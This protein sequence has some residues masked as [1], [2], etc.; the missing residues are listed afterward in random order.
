MKHDSLRVEFDGAE[1]E[2][3]YQDLISLE[4]EL[5]DRLA[6]MFRLTVALPPRPDGT[7]PHLD[8]DRLALWRKVV[9]TAGLED[10]ARRLISGYITHLRPSFGAQL[11]E[12]RLEVWGMDASV[13]M[14]RDDRLRAWPNKRDSDIA[15]EVF[16]QYGL[17][18]RVTGTDVV[19]EEEVS[20]IV[21]R[22]SDIRLLR[23][24]ASRNGF[25]C[26]VDGDVGHFGPPATDASPQPVLAAHFGPE[27]NLSTL[28][29]QAQALAP[30]GVSMTQLDRFNG[31]ILE[32]RAQPGHLPALGA[33]RVTDRPG[34]LRV[35][36]VVTT[37]LQEMTALCQSLQDEA[38]WFITGEGE[39]MANRY[40]TVLLPRGTV[41][42][43]GIGEAH[44][45][46]YYVSHV[47]HSFTGDGYVQAFKVR[48]NGLKLTGREQFTTGGAMAALIGGTK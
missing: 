47:T 14:D 33:R 22:E 20:T 42:I 10:D 41:T 16:G 39:V 37:G 3:L 15:T 11:N 35:G 30:T 5:D 24:L 2:E 44:S 1:I 45:G 34:V 9:I 7:W 23:R 13:L 19:H 28:R 26:Y 21:Q 17:T 40:G 43:K 36:H 38:E 27:T 48:R 4:V 25:D 29:L 32:A 12:C 6:A 8:D 31:D 46:V 18:P